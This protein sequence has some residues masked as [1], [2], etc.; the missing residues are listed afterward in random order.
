MPP[1]H[2][3]GRLAAR[4]TRPA[5]SRSV[6][7]L[8]V[9]LLGPP[10]AVA[11]A[12]AQG[13]DEEPAGRSEEV[14]AATLLGRVVEASTGAPVTGARVQVV[15]TGREGITL[16]SGRFRMDRL[17]S[18]V[19]AIR[20]HYL[21][22][23]SGET[24]VELAAGG[25]TEVGVALKVAPVPLPDLEVTVEA[26]APAGKLMGFYERRQRGLGQFI[27]EAEIDRLPA[28]RTTDL[29]RRMRGI[30]VVCSSRGLTRC[31]P[32]VT[33]A[34]GSLRGTRC[35]PQIYLDGMRMRGFGID[36]VIPED[37]EGIE[38][39]TG[40][41]QVPPRF[42]AISARCGVIALWTRT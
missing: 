21:G 28:A 38:V 35:T 32:V 34:A 5:P 23:A 39:Y 41:S 29:L 9:A 16:E 14:W 12:L 42:G 40:P 18:G 37:L 19:Y 4:R 1:R 26:G 20:V 2:Q 33:R 36:D 6:A 11:P 7:L 3:R 10:S 8:A 17:P 25:V 27:T 24:S 30:R 15:G 31:V 13:T 22:Y